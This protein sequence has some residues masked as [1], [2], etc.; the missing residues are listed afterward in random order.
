MLHCL[1]LLG[2]KLFQD[3]RKPRGLNR[4]IKVEI[5]NKCAKQTSQL[6]GPG[7]YHSDVDGKGG[8]VQEAQL[9]EFLVKELDHP[10][11]FYVMPAKGEAV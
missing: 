6:R 8:I 11:D 7:F 5:P 10:F 2:R 3:K 4:L 1:V 9:L